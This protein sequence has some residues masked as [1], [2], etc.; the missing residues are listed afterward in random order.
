[1]ALE[2]G[3]RLAQPFVLP[4]V[5]AHTHDGG[6]S[7]S[8]RW[9][10]AEGIRLAEELGDDR[11]HSQL[12]RVWAEL[13]GGPV[14]ASR[15]KAPMP[16]DSGG[17]PAP[18]PNPRPEYGV[19]HPVEPVSLAVAEAAPAVPSAPAT[20]VTYQQIVEW[21][22]RAATAPVPP[23]PFPSMTVV[24]TEHTIPPPP[25]HMKPVIDNRGR[26]G[27][28]GRGRGG[29]GGHEDRRPHR[30]GRAGDDVAATPR[31]SGAQKRA[32]DIPLSEAPS[33]GPIATVVTA[34]KADAWDSLLSWKDVK[35]GAPTAAAPAPS[36]CDEEYGIDD[37]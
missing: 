37:E 7:G 31:P 5:P 10:V 8:V 20:G 17:Q 13:F 11:R 22:E 23:S 18:V 19:D 16:V 30:G 26:G 15:V 27:R 34:A 25:A 12:A 2:Y 32:R 4:S 24:T 36:A 3:V 6:I 21:R 29:R 14:D 9:C 35:E 1:M 33:A 28:G